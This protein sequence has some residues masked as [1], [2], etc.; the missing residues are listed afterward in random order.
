MASFIA[1][2]RLELFWIANWTFTQKSISH[3]ESPMPPSAVESVAVLNKHSSCILPSESSLFGAL[4]QCNQ[5][6]ALAPMPVCR[7][8]KGM[9]AKGGNEHFHQPDCDSCLQFPKFVALFGQLCYRTLIIRKYKWE[10][11]QVSKSRI[12]IGHLPGGS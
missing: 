10:E 9:T 6:S 2:N 5:P 3:H 7:Q 11:T 8:L 12:M 4:A 1:S